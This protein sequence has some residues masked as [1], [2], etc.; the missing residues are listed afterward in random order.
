VPARH[1]AII[2]DA[3]V[4]G[5]LG[6]LAQPASI[7]VAALHVSGEQCADV[8]VQR[9]W[10]DAIKKIAVY[11]T[12]YLSGNELE[13]MWNSI[14]ATPCYR[15]SD[16]IQRDWAD[17]LAAVSRRD[18]AAIVRSGT[19][20]L[21]Q[22]EPTLAAEGAYI[23]TAMAAA[24]L[25]LGNLEGARTVLAIIPPGSGQGMYGLQ[26]RQLT[27]LVQQGSSGRAAPAPDVRSINAR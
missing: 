1:A 3:V 9:A 23:V 5:K 15:E 4:S 24:Q 8:G 27:A 22:P 12:P 6:Q 26:L 14:A 21:Q 11:T 16:E 20:L 17:L 18:A 2:R 7:E 25:R 10:R 19:L 13:G